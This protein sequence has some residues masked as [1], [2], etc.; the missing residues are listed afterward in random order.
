MIYRLSSISKHD[1][2]DPE[3][4]V[5]IHYNNHVFVLI[6][7]QMTREHIIS[8]YITFYIY[9][10]IT[11]NIYIYNHIYIYDHIYIYSVIYC[12]VMICDVS[13]KNPILPPNDPPKNACSFPASRARI[14][15]SEACR[16]P[17]AG[18]SRGSESLVEGTKPWAEQHGE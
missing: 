12:Y 7:I 17:R 6:N 11:I 14:R 10:S 9:I 13:I 4:F 5:S 18:G 1:H 3:I 16:G 8:T 15:M 2:Q